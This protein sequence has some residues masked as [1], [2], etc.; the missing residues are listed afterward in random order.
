MASRAGF[1]ADIPV[2]PRCGCQSGEKMVPRSKFLVGRIAK[3]TVFPESGLRCDSGIS[4]FLEHCL[5]HSF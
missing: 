4:C 3:K 2:G 5:G 1:E